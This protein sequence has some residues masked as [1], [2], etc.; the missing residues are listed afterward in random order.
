MLKLTTLKGVF[1]R[2]SSLA[3]T[4]ICSNRNYSNINL[5]QKRENFHIN[6]LLN[7]MNPC[8]NFIL[9]S[10]LLMSFVIFSPRMNHE[11]KFMTIVRS[12]VILPFMA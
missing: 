1:V 2:T 4:E 11:E 8:V 9:I 5:A 12:E 3:T 7:R 6:F 10:F